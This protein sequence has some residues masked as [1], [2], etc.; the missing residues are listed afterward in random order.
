MYPVHSK[1]VVSVQSLP[2][3]SFD[4]KQYTAASYTTVYEIP[5]CTINMSKCTKASFAI[6]WTFRCYSLPDNLR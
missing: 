4:L 5:E 2:S 1:T 6:V 3:M